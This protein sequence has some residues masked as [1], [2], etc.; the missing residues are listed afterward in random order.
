MAVSREA[1]RVRGN[2]ATSARPATSSPT[3]PVEDHH[4]DRG[5]PCLSGE[6]QRV[7]VVQVGSD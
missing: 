2:R 5:G 6:Q 4:E 3:T 7:A 1:V